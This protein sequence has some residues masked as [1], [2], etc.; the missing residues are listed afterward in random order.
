MFGDSL[1]IYKYSVTINKPKDFGLN[2]ST[3]PLACLFTSENLSSRNNKFQRKEEIFDGY[4]DNLLIN[5]N[6][7]EGKPVTS[8]LDKNFVFHYGIISASMALDM[9]KTNY[10]AFFNTLPND[11]KRDLTILLDDS[12]EKIECLPNTNEFSF[13]RKGFDSIRLSYDDLSAVLS[14]GAKRGLLLFSYAFNT[15]KDGGTLLVDEI[16]G[17]FHKNLVNNVIYLFN[18]EKINVNKAN[19]V[20]STHYA[21]ILDSFRRRDSIFVC[22]KNEKGIG[23]KN[24]YSDFKLRGELSKSNQL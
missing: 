3:H 23:I 5:S 7:N 9:K 20:F 19:L 13:K 12:I 8:L 4:S 15:L 22:S 24:V 1:S 2:D 10:L 11:L 21:E 14:D 16:E 6:S 17:S 18:D